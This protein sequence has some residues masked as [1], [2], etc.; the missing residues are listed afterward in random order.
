MC[1]LSARCARL[2]LGPAAGR[3]PGRRDYM[4]ARTC[5][6]ARCHARIIAIPQQ[7]QHACAPMAG[8][9]ATGDAYTLARSQSGRPV[10]A[11][12]GYIAFRE[13]LVT[14]TPVSTARFIGRD[15]CRR[16]CSSCW[17]ADCLVPVTAPL[18]LSLS[19]SLS[20]WA[21]RCTGA[22]RGDPITRDSSPRGQL[23]PWV[24]RAV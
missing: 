1:V 3:A 12:A 4:R 15:D 9:L 24:T 8:A 7:Q 16:T 18:T 21:E 10:H 5:F 11:R 19:P 20:L 23:Q 13:T 14:S 6:Q 17:C 22:Q 2:T